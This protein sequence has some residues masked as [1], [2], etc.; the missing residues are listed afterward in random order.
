MSASST[1]F[2]NSPMESSGSN[3]RLRVDGSHGSRH[4]MG[5]LPGDG[6]RLVQRRSRGSM[7][8]EA[9][10]RP[11]PVTPTPTVTCNFVQHP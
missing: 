1:W 11:P 2:A 10:N 5:S 6:H 3:G 9:G 7:T 8:V 4:G